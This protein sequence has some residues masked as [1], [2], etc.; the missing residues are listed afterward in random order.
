M[1]DN[2]IIDAQKDLQARKNSVGWVNYAKIMARWRKFI[3]ISV[4]VVTLIAGVISFILPKWYTGT[5]S[6]LPPKEESLLGGLSGVTSLLRDLAPVKGLSGLGGGQR[7]LLNYLAILSSRRA[8]DSLITKFNLMQVYDIASLEKTREALEDNTEFQIAENGSLVIEVLDTDPQRAAD[9]ANYYVTVL[10]QIS[11]E[12]GTQE[13][14]ANREFIER[15]LAQ[16]E[17]D[18]KEVE[19]S[20]RA[21]Q[22]K[23]GLIVLPQETQTSISA[24]A[25]LYA[26]KTKKEIEAGVLERTVGA[27]NQALKNV[28]IELSELNKKIKDIPELGTASLRLYREYMIQNKIYELMKPLYEQVKFQEQ[29]DTPSVVVLD[30]AVPAER[31]TKPKRLIIIASSCISSLLLSL[32]AVTLVEKWRTFKSE[33]SEE[34]N[35]LVVAFKRKRETVENK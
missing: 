33:L 22:E 1:D 28:R 8:K 11:T 7:G 13:A 31:K 4:G 18:L 6:V 24:V 35:E 5:A 29:K 27:D 17:A 14:R 10:N 26:E 20:L 19:D 30:K 34:Y 15:R 32:I 25:S 3:F 12:L 16:N 9:M 23:H 2:I 21:F